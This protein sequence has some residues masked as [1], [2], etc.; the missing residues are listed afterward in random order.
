VDHHRTEF[1]NENVGVACA[2]LHYKDM[3]IQSPATVLAGLWRQLIFRKPMPAG[4]PAHKLYQ[5]HHGKDSVPSID[6][7]AA[8]LRSAFREY[9]KV[10][11]LIDAL[12]ECPEDARRTL[13]K[14]LAALSPSVSLL[15]TSRPNIN[16][17]DA[18]FFPNLQDFEIRATEDDIRRY[19][20]GRIQHGRWPQ[21]LEARPELRREIETKI[22]EDYDG[23]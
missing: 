19:F 22:I 4:S 13:L 8:V 16:P 3:D 17:P 6:E 20:D 14:H 15:M 2:Y 23:T 10:Y 12:D 21:H 9:S 7:V 18:T 1:K 5:R 11:I